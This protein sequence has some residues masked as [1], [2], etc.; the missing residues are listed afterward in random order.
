MFLTNRV[1][2][3]FPMYTSLLRGIHHQEFGVCPSKPCF[4]IL[5]C[6]YVSINGYNTVLCDFKMHK[7]WYLIIFSAT[8]FLCDN[9]FL[10]SIFDDIDIRLIHSY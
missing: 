3:K 2:M 7:K 8:C 5:H 10:R 1:K 6:I 4:Y 9:V